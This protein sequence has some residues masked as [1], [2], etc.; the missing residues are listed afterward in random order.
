MKKIYLASLL[1]GLLVT[2]ISCSDVDENEIYQN[3]FHKILLLKTNGVL[4]LT[5]YN[6][7]EDSNYEFSVMKSGT[8]PETTANA[9]ISPMTE[10][11]LQTYSD[12][13][14][15]NLL[16]VPSNC[17]ELSEKELYFNPNER[18]KKIELALHTNMIAQLPASEADYVIPLILKSENDSINESK[19][20]LIIKPNI[21]IPSVLFKQTGLV[22]QYCGK[23]KTTIEVP[24]ELQIDNKWDFTCTVGV[25][26]SKIQGNTLLRKGYTLANDGVVTFSKGNK[27]ATL[28][29][30]VD[31]AEAELE[32]LNM[33]TL[34]LP[35]SIESVSLETFGKDQEAYLLGINSQYPLMSNMLSTNAQE[36]SEGALSNI[37]DGKIGTYFHS[38]W[39]IAISEEHYVQVDLPESYSSFMFS[40]INREAN[41]NAALGIFDVSVS[42][43]KK[44]FTKIKSFDKDIDG[45]PGTGA[46]VFNSTELKS[47][48]AFNS[49]RFTCKK[50]WTGGAYFV[51]SEFSLYVL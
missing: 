37:L 36:P 16:E 46:G 15:L 38:A 27:S 19:N 28:K 7:G 49:I 25:D 9:Y 24:L 43:D 51:W 5:V 41:G 21:I 40:Y 48:S 34:V 26:E 20:I 45:L 12:D 4:D 14:G 13:R 10:E 30:T 44:N 22:T 29:V 42:S 35:L 47:E 3:E 23:G 50:N 31:R 6:T 17:Y 32:E 2:Q 39:S 33:E 8:S 1:L 18:Y 11:E